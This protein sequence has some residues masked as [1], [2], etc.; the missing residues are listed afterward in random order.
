VGSSI[1]GR[2]RQ[3]LADLLAR[4]GP[5]QPTLCTGWTTADLVA[6]L[7][8]RE[9]RPDAAIGILGG[10]L[11]KWNKKVMAKSA[12]RFSRN[13]ERL[14]TGPPF[15]SPMRWFDSQ[16]NTFE[17]LIHHEDARRAQP[18]WQPR[19][20]SAIDAQLWKLIER[21]SRWLMRRLDAPL[22]LIANGRMIGSSQGT[23]VRGEPLEL[24]LYLAG[25][26]EAAL[27]NISGQAPD[28]SQLRN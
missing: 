22:T 9:R 12:P 23:C 18:G 16:L 19:D 21:S 3:A 17:M 2:E 14:R 6:H 20:L 7:V 11:A 26:V 24:L 8:L 5:D 10:P 28:Q 4:L 27:V 13:V 1:A 15:W 25:R